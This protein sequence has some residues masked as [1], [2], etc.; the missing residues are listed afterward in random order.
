MKTS[1][2]Y[3]EESKTQSNCVRTYIENPDCFIISLREGSLYSQNR[4]TIEYRINKNSLDRVQTRGRFNSNLNEVWDVPLEIL[5]N[6]V[7]TLYS[8]NKFDLPK[9][10]K[11]FTNGKRIERCAIFPDEDN[12]MKFLHPV[13]NE[14]IP[15]A[16]SSQIEFFGQVQN[17]FENYDLPF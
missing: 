1:A 13:W 10:I 8:K 2:Q 9:L 14:K 16:R 4:T 6:R 3:T 7:N 5:D 12:K 17:D 11:E 15:N